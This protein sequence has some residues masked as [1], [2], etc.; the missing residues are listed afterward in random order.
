LDPR[1]AAPYLLVGIVAACAG[2]P[3]IARVNA[4]RALERDPGSPF[5]Q[6]I[7][8]RACLGSKCVKE[9]LK[10]LQRGRWFAHLRGDPLSMFSDLLAVEIQIWQSL[11]EFSKAEGAIQ[12][13][14]RIQPDH[15]IALWTR[16]KMTFQRE[17]MTLAAWERFEARYGV[18]YTSAPF[19]PLDRM[20]DGSPLNGRRI[21]VFG[22]GGLGDAVMFVRYAELV[23]ARGGR[24]VLGVAPELVELM[25]SAPGVD[26]VV[27]YS[28]DDPIPDEFD[29]I[30]PMYGLPK[31]FNTTEETAAPRIPY[32]SVPAERVEPWRQ[33]IGREGLNIGIGWAASGFQR[34]LPLAEFAPLAE[35]PRV[36]LYSLQRIA[37]VEQLPEATFQITDLQDGPADIVE[38][39]A[40][41]LALD[42][43]IGVDSL[44]VHLAGALGRPIW[45]ALLHCPDWRWLQVDRRD[46][47]R[48]PTIRLFRQA[49][50]GDW[51]SVIAQMVAELRVGGV[52][53]AVTRLR[54]EAA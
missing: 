25:R 6:L 22:D 5:A 12:A 34:S 27:N 28:S 33:R 26:S 1:S 16:A 31:I 54:P 21:L 7:L 48:Y 29:L 20:W 9:G 41:I 23:K 38:T 2:E 32:L 36:Q 3:E 43:V 10:H 4:I 46:S 44:L 35:L 18:R 49:A 24:V 45:A 17:G 53:A 40:M 50:P 42:L 51:G 39:G 11:R 47:P 13:A 14:L 8:A 15:A 37:G 30:V 52:N 19:I